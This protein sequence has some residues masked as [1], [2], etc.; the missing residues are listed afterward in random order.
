MVFTEYHFP[1][2]PPVFDKVKTGFAQCLPDGLVCSP[3]RILE[4]FRSVLFLAGKFGQLHL[5]RLL[6]AA[7][8]ESQVEISVEIIRH[9]VAVIEV[10]RHHE[11]ADIQHHLFRTV[12]QG[13]VGR[14]IVM[15]DVILN[16]PGFYGKSLEIS[17][18]QPNVDGMVVL[19]LD[20]EFVS[21]IGLL[22]P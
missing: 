9:R 7:Y 16:L 2:M 4:L 8:S 21:R 13:L 6:V 11:I 12:S 1:G 22:E 5:I 17:F 14:D 19:A 10:V 20:R 15:V 18:H 3:F